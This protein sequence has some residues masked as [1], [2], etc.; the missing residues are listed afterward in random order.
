MVQQRRRR[1]AAP[2]KIAAAAPRPRPATRSAGCSSSSRPP[3]TAPRRAATPSTSA[4]ATAGDLRPQRRAALSSLGGV[5]PP[6]PDSPPRRRGRSPRRERNTG[7]REAAN[8]LVHKPSRAQLRPAPGPSCRYSEIEGF[9][10]PSRIEDYALIGDCQTAALVG[11][12]RLDR[13]AVLAAL[14]L[15]RLLRRAAG[16][17]GARPLAARPGRRGP[18]AS[19][20]ATAT[21]ARARDR[22]R[23][24]RRAPSRV[25]RL[26]AAARR[27]AGPRPRRRG[28]ARAGADAHGAGRS[29][30]TTARSC[31]GCAGST[32]GISR[33]RRARHA[34]LCAPPVALRGEDL[35]TVRRVHRRARASACPFVLTWHPSHRAG[36]AA[37]ID[38][39]DALARDRAT[40]GET[41]RPLHL[42]GR[43]ARRGACAR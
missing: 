42:P 16:H 14:R 7:G 18:R 21:D 43:V 34:L 35:T 3:S 37:A 36:A 38:A 31:R 26:H 9:T 40:G 30:S 15:R 6:L 13:L 12:R 28:A 29:A 41:G 23:D 27:R 25:D 32:A 39:E 1:E 24:R 2:L 4:A 19:A 10:M 22:V 17:A 11:A 20:G 5:G 8:R 33:R